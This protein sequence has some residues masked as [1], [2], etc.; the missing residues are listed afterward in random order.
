MEPPGTTW[1]ANQLVRSVVIDQEGNYGLIMNAPWT[2][3][4]TVLYAKGETLVILIEDF[5]GGEKNS[6]R[7]MS[8]EELIA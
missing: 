7:V 5:E 6:F 3:P 2:N 4:G 1:I 8:C